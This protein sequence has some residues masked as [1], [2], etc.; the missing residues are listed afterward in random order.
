MRRWMVLIVPVVLLL[1]GC[2]GGGGKQLTALEIVSRAADATT[3]SG[4]ARFEMTIDTSGAGAGA[5]ASIEAR[6]I[7]D[8]AGKRMSMTMSIPQAGDMEAV[9]DGST[10][11]MRFPMFQQALGVDSPWVSMD[12]ERLAA[13][14]GIDVSQLQAGANNDPTQALQALRGASDDLAEVG[15]EEVRGVETTHYRGTMDLRKAGE[16]Q[17]ADKEQIERL[18]AQVGQDTLPMDVWIDD[19]GLVRRMRMSPGA[20]GVDVDVDLELF[21]YGTDETVEVPPPDQVTDVTDVIAAQAGALE[22]AGG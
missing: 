21:D 9:L 22:G 8:M 20:D 11:Y 7:A 4:T 12:V 6:G 13:M 3:E 2:G 14:Q 5:D 15:S 18:L 17:G 1:A 19:D 10:M 16:Q